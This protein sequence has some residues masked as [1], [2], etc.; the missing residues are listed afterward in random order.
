MIAKTGEA[1]LVAAGMA[2]Q[3]GWSL[4][5]GFVL[6]GIIQ[7]VVSKERMREQLGRDGLREIALATGYGA[8]SS[9]CSYAAAALS[10]TLFKK[11]AALTPSLAFLFSSTN[12]VVEL[13]II[14]YLL[15]GW[16]FTLAEWLGGVVLVAIMSLLVKLTYPKKL[17]QEARSHVERGV[18][19]QHGRETVEGATLWAKLRNPRT[20]VLVAQ[21]VAMDWSMLWK[22]VIGGF[23]IAGALATFVPSRVWKSLFLE[24]APVVVQIP[25]NAFAGAVIAILTFVC[26]IGTFPWQRYFGEPVSRSEG[27]CLF[28]TLTLSYCRCSTSTGNTTA[29][30]WLHTS[31]QSSSRRW[32]DRR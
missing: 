19:H 1:L 2:W 16:Q 7:A 28:C 25:A 5:L 12:L 30:R 11:G 31:S 14:L 15:M 24:G 4:V 27:C 10:K 21:S 22:D 26:S 17:V 20:P 23:L 32:S 13:G 6:S 29:G 9:S 8:A 3:V 18:E